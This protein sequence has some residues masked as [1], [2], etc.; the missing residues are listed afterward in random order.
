MRMNCITGT[1]VGKILGFDKN[2]T[3]TKLLKEKV[4]KESNRKFSQKTLELF[5]LGNNFIYKSRSSL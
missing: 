1:D 3:R 4:N 2:C 5:D